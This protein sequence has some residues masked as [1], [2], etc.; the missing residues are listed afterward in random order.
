[1]NDSGT[2][3]IIST[4]LLNDPKVAALKQGRLGSRHLRFAF[5]EAKDGYRRLAGGG[6][7]CGD[8]PIGAFLQALSHGMPLVLMPVVLTGRFH[9]DAIYYNP[10]RGSLDP[11]RLE[12][13]RIG[14]NA[15][16]HTSGIWLRGLLES[17]Y[18]LDHRRMRWVTLTDSYLDAYRDPD[19]CEQAPPGSSLQDMLLD[20]SID[21]AILG[22]SGAN[23]VRF[24]LLF[25]DA[26]E[27]ARGWQRKFGAVP[28]N[29][30]L[31]IHQRLLHEPTLISEIYRLFVESKAAA[32]LPPGKPDLTPY[33]IEANQRALELVIDY[34][35]RQQVI[36]KPFAVDT[37]FDP[38][39]AIL[40]GR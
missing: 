31:V 26:A 27:A 23:D 20:G 25:A 35:V 34:A 2:T 17:E 12:G 3:T 1:M 32:P 24:K 21:A 13:K 8:L 29:H 10:A 37:L 33:G 38:V 18:G 15:Y 40:G 39:A 36:P 7:D 5:A 28:I 9:H 14:V 16:T 19:I 22:P 30:M 6:F 11:G 4:F